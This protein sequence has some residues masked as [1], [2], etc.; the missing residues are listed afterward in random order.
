[1]HPKLPR[2]TSYNEN[3]IVPHYNDA[4]DSDV[5]RQSRR[6]STQQTECP[7]PWQWHNCQDQAVVCMVR[8]YSA[9][10][11]RDRSGK[12]F[13]SKFNWIGISHQ[14]FSYSLN[15]NRVLIFFS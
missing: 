4:L 7:Q 11:Q 3:K 6:M 10:Q 13:H 12:N 1:M 5:G 15:W 14:Q 2:G 9:Q 8:Y